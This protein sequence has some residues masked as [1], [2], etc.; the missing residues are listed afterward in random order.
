MSAASQAARI[1]HLCDGL[2]SS[3]DPLAKLQ[4]LA[5]VE[6]TSDVLAAL[7][8]GQAFRGCV[9]G[10]KALREHSSFSVQQ[11]AKALYKQWKRAYKRN[12]Q[13]DGDG[14][15]GKRKQKRGAESSRE[16]KRKKKKPKKQRN[17]VK[18]GDAVWIYTKKDGWNKRVVVRPSGGTHRWHLDNGL[19]KNLDPEKWGLG[20]AAEWCFGHEFAGDDIVEIE[21][22]SGENE[23]VDAGGKTSCL[24]HSSQMNRR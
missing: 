22:T 8:Q 10:V 16:E 6:L 14:D 13:A 4:L 20:E 7:M 17:Q 24:S 5:G 9:E 23:K 21:V 11:S 2:A 15:S 18:A 3:D 12:N 19:V 1:Q